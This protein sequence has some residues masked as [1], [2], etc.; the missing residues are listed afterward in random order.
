MA[1]QLPGDAGRVSS[2]ETLPPGPKRSPCFGAHRQHR[3]GLLHQ[4]PG[5]S[6]FVPPLQAGAPDPCVVPGQAPLAESSSY[7]GLRPGEWMLHPK[8][9][10]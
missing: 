4:P 1:H 5:R 7:S 10:K 2:T 9:V 6:V 8:V 3:G